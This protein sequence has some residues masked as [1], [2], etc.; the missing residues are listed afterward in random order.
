MP[1]SENARGA[2]YMSVAMTAFTVNDACMKA[3]TQALPLYQAMFLRGVFATIALLAI[4][5]H[6]G[7]LRFAMQAAQGGHHFCTGVPQ[8]VGVVQVFQAAA[9]GGVQARPVR[10]QHVDH[11]LANRLQ[12]LVV[13]TGQI[14]PK[15]GRKAVA[16]SGFEPAQ[17]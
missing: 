9:Q 12:C 7:S 4:G 6:M 2:I 17:G 1:W 11:R 14:R 8:G 3:V 13:I 10:A 15:K 5:W 16:K